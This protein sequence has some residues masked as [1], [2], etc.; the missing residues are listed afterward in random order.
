MEQHPIC[1]STSCPNS[2]TALLGVRDNKG[3]YLTVP[4]TTV[5]NG[6]CSC[7]SLYCAIMLAEPAHHAAW[8]P[9][10]SVCDPSMG[11]NYSS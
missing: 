10:Q 1:R 8:C 6:S 4:G 5:N 11:L 7:C 2:E 3:P 9:T